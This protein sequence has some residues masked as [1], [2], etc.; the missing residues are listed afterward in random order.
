MTKGEQSIANRD[1]S[2]WVVVPRPRKLV[3][4]VSKKVGNI[5]EGWQVKR[6]GN[7]GQGARLTRTVSYV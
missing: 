2:G 6:A 3:L 4:Q 1:K 5:N 7:K